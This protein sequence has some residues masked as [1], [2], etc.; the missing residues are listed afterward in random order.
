MAFIQNK[1]LKYYIGYN[2]FFDE[3]EKI[4]SIKNTSN[5][6]FDIL[7][8][9][10]NKYEINVALAGI[11]PD[12]I[13]INTVNDFLI[14]D[15]R[16]KPL[17]S[18]Q[19]IIHKGIQNNS[20]PKRKRGVYKKMKVS[21]AGKDGSSASSSMSTKEKWGWGLLMVF[22]V[23]ALVVSSIAIAKAYNEDTSYASAS[24]TTLSPTASPTA[25]PGGQTPAPTPVP[26]PKPG[27]KTTNSPTASPTPGG[28]SPPGT[29]S[30]SGSGS[31]HHSSG[32]GSKPAGPCVSIPKN[33]CSLNPD[34]VI[35][36]QCCKDMTCEP[37]PSNPGAGTCQKTTPG[38]SSGSSSGSR[39]N[40]PDDVCNQYKTNS[41]CTSQIL[42]ATC[43]WC[44]V[45]IK[46]SGSYNPPHQKCGTMRRT[47][48]SCSGTWTKPLPCTQ[49]ES[50]NNCLINGQS[51]C[52]ER[53]SGNSC[54]DNSLTCDW[55][56]PIQTRRLRGN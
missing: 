1:F 13:T 19:D 47:D 23:A 40:T 4:S 3:I 11:A 30:S 12:Q 43:G 22:C 31:T 7:K 53:N 18:N 52:H 39:P 15:V 33:W 20:I 56:A 25:K 5:L 21:G 50:H 44:S 36:Q 17:S 6:A 9:D 2:D 16:Q 28:S 24:V 29:S 41:T 49:C 35:T 54:V 14:L 8:Y 48:L 10:E 42:N 46:Y 27:G 38:S 51:A 32:S 26:T 34:A 55:E 45:N 37:N